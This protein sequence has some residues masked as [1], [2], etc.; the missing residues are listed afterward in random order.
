MPHL[1]ASSLTLAPWLSAELPR[2]RL[3]RRIAVMIRRSSR[4]LLRLARSRTAERA[5]G[6][7]LVMYGMGMMV[8]LGMA[9]LAL[10][11]SVALNTKR[12]YQKIAAVCSV[13]GAQ[14]FPT[15]APTPVANPDT[16]AAKAQ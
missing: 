14:W 6:Q 4:N 7:I 10:D 2:H 3:N 1:L 15:P 9:A 5:P 12:E 16:S 8:L 13:V 11:V